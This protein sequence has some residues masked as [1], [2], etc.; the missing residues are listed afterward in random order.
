MMIGATPGGRLNHGMH[1]DDVLD[2][3]NYYL[4]HDNGGRGVV[5][6]GH[7][8]GSFILDEL[9]RNEMDGK[10]VQSR[11]VSVIA[12]GAT[13][14]MPKDS[15]AAFPHIP[16]ASW[17]LKPGAPLFTRRFALPF[18]RPRTRISERSQPTIRSPHA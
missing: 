14:P 5:L 10:P 4:E 18:R 16:D 2:A 9:I 3:W 1:Y 15:D 12:P 6:I 7:S 17:L 8:Q 13:L 11:I